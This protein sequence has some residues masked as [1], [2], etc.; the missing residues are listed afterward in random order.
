MAGRRR[1]AGAIIVAAGSGSRFG[2]RTPKQFVRLL[3]KPLLL[4][5]LETIR[6]APGIGPVVL[7]AARRHVSRVRGIL[8]T[9]GFG[10]E[11]KVVPGGRQRQNSVFNGLQAFD[12]PPKV[13]LVHDAARPLVTKEMIRALLRLAVKHK[14][15]IAALP[16]TDTLKKEK[17]AGFAGRTIPRSGLWLAQTPPGFSY[18]LLMAAHQTARKA[19]LAA[20]DDAALVEYIGVPVRIFRGSPRNIKVTTRS[21]L[22]LAEMWLKRDVGK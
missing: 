22:R 14:A 18:D 19:G 20:T 6:S 3:G 21:D 17:R 15:V 16:V 9:A 12:D 10:A 7:V 4:H 1:N 8:E 2:G 11:C 5:A 13:V